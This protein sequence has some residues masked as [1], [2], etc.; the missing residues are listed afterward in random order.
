MHMMSI[1]R[2]AAEKHVAVS[3]LAAA[4]KHTVKRG[5]CLLSRG[6]NV[7]NV[8]VFR[9]KEGWAG[10]ATFLDRVGGSVTIL[11]KGRKTTFPNTRVKPAFRSI[12]SAHEGDDDDAQNDVGDTLED[13]VGNALEDDVGDTLYYDVDVA[14]ED[15]IGDAEESSEHFG[16]Y[17]T[18]LVNNLHDKRFEIAIKAEIV[19]LLSRDVFEL[20]R[21][22]SPLRQQHHGFKISSRCEELR[23]DP[24]CLKSTSSHIRIHG[25]REGTDIDRRTHSQSDEH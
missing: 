4:D 8:L 21:E 6:H 19:G 10:P 5:N 23:D 11:F 2:D 22:R 3:R 17:I 9:E 25:C 16:T 24:T 13:D 15:D 12:C 7:D 1:A 18:D 14:L 20:E